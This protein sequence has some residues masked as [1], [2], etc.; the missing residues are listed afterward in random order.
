MKKFNEMTMRALLIFF[1]SIAL[2]S[3]AI[4]IYEATESL[5][6]ASIPC[7]ILPFIIIKLASDED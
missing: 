4:S 3:L 5:L 6:L 7:L 2:V 1:S